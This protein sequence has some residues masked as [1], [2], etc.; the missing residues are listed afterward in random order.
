MSFPLKNAL[1][2]GAI[3]TPANAWFL[4]ST[5]VQILNGISIGSAVFAQL[6]AEGRYTLQRAASVPLKIAS[7]HGGSEPN[8]IYTWF[9]VVSDI[10]IFVLK[11]DVKL[12]N[13]VPWPTQISTQTTSRSVQPFLI[14]FVHRNG[15]P[16]TK[17]SWA[18]VW[19][20]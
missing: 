5:G 19:P 15:K 16:V 12:T 13:V 1:S 14:I 4:E 9:L 20:L 6:A 10:A 2:Y 3:S 7:S 18:T 11:R 17:M 8:L